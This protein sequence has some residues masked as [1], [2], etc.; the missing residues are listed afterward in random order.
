MS[1]PQR[2][3][4]PHWTIPLQIV[5]LPLEVGNV[6]EGSKQHSK[7]GGGHGMLGRTGRHNPVMVHRDR[8]G[9]LDL[10]LEPLEL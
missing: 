1:S 5:H 3:H 8:H 2:I 10:E 7:G 4:Q 6:R 9:V